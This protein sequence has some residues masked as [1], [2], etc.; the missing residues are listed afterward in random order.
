MPL[1]IVP[2]IAKKIPHK[3][4][5]HSE[6]MV[7]DYHWLRDNKWPNVKNTDILNHLKEENKYTEQFFAPQKKITDSIYKSLIGRIKLADKSIEAKDKNYYYFTLT[8]E[9]F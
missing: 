1:N 2:P 3:Q 8:K 6:T 4:K 5:I 7:D 9:R